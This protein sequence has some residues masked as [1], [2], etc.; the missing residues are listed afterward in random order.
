MVED[1]VPVE[2][3]KP[4]RYTRHVAPDSRSLSLTFDIGEVALAAS[5]EIASPEEN[6]DRSERGNS[7]V[8]KIFGFASG[9][10]NGENGFGDLREAKNGLIASVIKNKKERTERSN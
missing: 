6:E 5:S 1:P 2:T 9:L 4:S 7:V 3:T 8:K 10:K